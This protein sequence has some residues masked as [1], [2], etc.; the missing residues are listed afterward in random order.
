MGLLTEEEIATII[1]ALLDGNGPSTE[2]EI[3]IAVKWGNEA[4]VSAALLECVLERKVEMSLKDGELLFHS[5]D[6]NNART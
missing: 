2:D 6:N 1:E 3:L 4:R 5:K